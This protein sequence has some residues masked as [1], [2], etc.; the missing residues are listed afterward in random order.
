[1]GRME[2]NSSHEVRRDVVGNW[3]R[4][5]DAMNEKKLG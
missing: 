3:G 1:M 2:R 5:S 4:V